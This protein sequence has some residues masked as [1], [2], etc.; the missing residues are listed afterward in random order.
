MP[1]PVAVVTW[2]SP[3]LVTRFGLP[4]GSICG[5]LA[6]SEGAIDVENFLP[7]PSFVDVI[8]LVC[9]HYLD[10]GLVEFARE[11]PEQAVAVIDQRSPDVDAEIPAEDII[12]SYSVA[13]GSIGEYTPNPAYRLVTPVGHFQLTPWLRKCLATAV[14]PR[15]PGTL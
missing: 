3:D 14:I 1:E 10:P 7:Q 13:G 4:N 9:R 15:P 8:H 6:D 11:V 12:G 5:V 2:W